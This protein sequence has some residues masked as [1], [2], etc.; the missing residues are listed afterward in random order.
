ME[1][2]EK[3]GG[4]FNNFADE[5]TPDHFR[6]LVTRQLRRISNCYGGSKGQSGPSVVK[7][8][9]MKLIEP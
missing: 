4:T 9:A 6:K 7:D 3:G 5:A 8:K 1:Q 2:C